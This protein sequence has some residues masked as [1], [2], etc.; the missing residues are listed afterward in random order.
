[1]NALRQLFTP[2][3]ILVIKPRN[4][5]TAKMIPRTNAKVPP[6]LT[7]TQERTAKVRFSKNANAQIPG[8]YAGSSA[9]SL[10]RS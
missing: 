8:E 4:E 6:T 9:N 5:S 1:M 7:A 3:T 2:P 10:M